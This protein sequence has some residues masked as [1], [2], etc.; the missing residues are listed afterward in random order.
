MLKLI[1]RMR[2][3]IHGE[4]LRTITLQPGGRPTENPVEL[5]ANDAAKSCTDIVFLGDDP[6]AW[7]LHSEHGRMHLGADRYVESLLPHAVS[8]FND[9]MVATR[10]NDFRASTRKN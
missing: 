6:A 5:G 7:G 10:S 2:N 8:L 1:S 3:T 4:A 9:L